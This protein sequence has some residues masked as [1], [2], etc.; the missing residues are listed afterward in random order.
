MAGPAKPVN[1]DPFMQPVPGY[2]LTQTPGKYP[3]DSPPAEVDPDIVVSKMIDRLEEP[4]KRDRMLK[5]MLAGISIEEITGTIAMAGFMEGRFSVDIGELIKGPIG[6][7]L[8][9]LADEH[10]IP[11]QVYKDEEGM[12]RE[13][14]GQLDDGTILEIMRRRNPKLHNYMMGGYQEEQDELLIEQ[15]EQEEKMSGGMLGVTEM[16]DMPMEEQL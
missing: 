12:K 7:Y 3:W 16:E 14:E 10:Q 1:D 6:V 8:M 4:D 15:M 5:L 9:G 13:R 11:V 2:S